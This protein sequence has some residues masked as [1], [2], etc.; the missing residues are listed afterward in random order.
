MR[1]S[2]NSSKNFPSQDKIEIVE[3]KGS[4]HP[5]SL[6]CKIAENSCRQLCFYY[7]DNYK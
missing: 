4:G 6:A 2:I 3:R 7:K 5:D 1:V